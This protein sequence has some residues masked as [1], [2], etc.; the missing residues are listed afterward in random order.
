M[1]ADECSERL[2]FACG[3]C[4]PRIKF[5]AGDN[6]P[7]RPRRADS[8][9]VQLLAEPATTT[10]TQHR[11]KWLVLPLGF[12]LGILLVVQM[13]LLTSRYRRRVAAA[14][15]AGASRAAFTAGHARSRSNGGG[16]EMNS[17]YFDAQDKLLLA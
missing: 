3:F 16:D 8:M 2:S 6:H 1:H 10:V 7:L 17:D 12:V 4:L 5:A 14:A 11:A 15:A 13:A 9:G